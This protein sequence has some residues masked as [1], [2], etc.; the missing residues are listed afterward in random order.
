L[1]VIELKNPADENATVKSAFKQLQTYK[2]A[3]PGLFTYNGLM[4]ISDGLEAKAGSLSAELSR[5]MAW[6]TSDGETEA[7]PFELA[8]NAEVLALGG[9]HV[10]T[11]YSYSDYI[12]SLLNKVPTNSSGIYQYSTSKLDYFIIPTTN[13]L[14]LGSKNK[15]Q[16]EHESKALV[17]ADVV[18]VKTL[19]YLTRENGKLYLQALFKEMKYDS[20][21]EYPYEWGD[22][23]KF[24]V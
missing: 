2:Y 22:D 1:V 7:S 20:T 9:V 18:A 11:H 5:F 24:D 17:A 10:D 15:L 14:Y 8:D 6:K 16:V 3:I 13:E 4:V 19:P 23:S 21:K 12:S